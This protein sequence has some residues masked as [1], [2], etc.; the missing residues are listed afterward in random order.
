MYIGLCSYLPWEGM[1]CLRAGGRKEKDQESSEFDVNLGEEKCSLN[2]SAPSSVITLVIFNFYK[3]CAFHLLAHPVR[4][5]CSCWPFASSPSFTL[6]FRSADKLIKGALPS[7]TRASS[8]SLARQNLVAQ[9]IKRNYLLPVGDVCA[10]GLLFP[11]YF[12]FS[13][14]IIPYLLITIFCNTCIFSRETIIYSLN[15]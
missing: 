14:M 9:V 2:G 13:N 15:S 11:L 8:T 4:L 6:M 3:L 5:L 12:Y 1:R 10:Q 7:L